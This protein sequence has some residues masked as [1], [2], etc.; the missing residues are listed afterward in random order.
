MMSRRKGSNRIST[1]Y[2]A[3]M[4]YKYE[5][6]GYSRHRIAMELEVS[7]RM[8][9]NYVNM[10][11]QNGKYLNEVL[12]SSG[13]VLQSREFMKDLWLPDSAFYDEESIGKDLELQG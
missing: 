10:W 8:V 1:A 13:L 6:L 3:M 7:E 4:A 2:R 5:M 9:G 11:L 12:K